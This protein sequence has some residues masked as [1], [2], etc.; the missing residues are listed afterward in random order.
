MRPAPLR[1]PA[2]ALAALALAAGAVGAAAQP[3][4]RADE[5]LDFDRPEAWAMKYF[6]TVS[7][8]SGFGPPEPS[9]AGSVSLSVEV[10]WIPEIGADDAQVGFGG[11]KAEDVNKAPVLVRPRLDLGLPADWTL[12]VGYVPPLDLFDAEAHLLTVSLGRPL[13]HHG[14]WRAGGRLYGQIGTVYSDITCPDE[15]AARGDDPVGNPYRCQEPS[16]DRV[17][18][19]YA[20]LEL[21][22]G[23]DDGGRL[24]PHLALGVDRLDMAFEVD[25]LTAG[26]RDRSL[27]T[28]EGTVWHAAA[29][30]TYRAERAPAIALEVYYTPLSVD[31]GA[32]GGSENDPL[33]NVRLLATHRLR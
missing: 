11:T 20:G 12:T 6:T 25:A 8:T 2:L 3:V 31:R 17:D 32:P 1:R 16:E 14:P 4:L 5:K 23:R 24:A 10:G 28:A 30:L 29:G 9:E 7:V 21:A 27:L 18:L 19:R 13:W 33:L 15:V 26:F 22:L